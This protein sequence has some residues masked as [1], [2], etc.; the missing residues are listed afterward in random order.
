VVTGESTNIG[1]VVFGDD[2]KY[3]DH[4]LA[5]LDRAKSRGD[6]PKDNDGMWLEEWIKGFVDVKEVARRNDTTGAMM[7]SI[8]ISNPHGS[9]LAAPHLL[10]FIFPKMVKE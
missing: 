3:H 2:D 6:F 4:R 1:V 9:I 8:Q 5:K 7:S 10:E